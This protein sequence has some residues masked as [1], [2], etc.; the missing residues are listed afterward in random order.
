[1]EALRQMGPTLLT[2]ANS[3]LSSLPLAGTRQGDIVSTNIGQV[4]TFSQAQRLPVTHIGWVE[5][6]VKRFTQNTIV[7]DIRIIAEYLQT[8]FTRTGPACQVA[9]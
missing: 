8:R 5:C 7:F 1:M 9:I 3:T 2:K 6:F 4:S